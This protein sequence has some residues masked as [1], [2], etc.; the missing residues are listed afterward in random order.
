MRAGAGGGGRRQRCGASGGWVSVRDLVRGW[1]RRCTIETMRRRLGGFAV[2]RV[3]APVTH[4]SGTT[5]GR[6]R[7]SV[8]AR[9]LGVA[10]VAWCGVALATPAY[11]FIYW[12]NRGGTTIGRANLDGSSPNQ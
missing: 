8:V 4:R 3:D 2:S 1:R 9:V 10:V 12:A 6:R 11:G 5:R 7:R